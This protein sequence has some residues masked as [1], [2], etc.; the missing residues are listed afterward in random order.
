MLYYTVL[1]LISSKHQQV[2]A[3][4]AAGI[5]KVDQNCEIP[6]ITENL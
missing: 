1:E 5:N 6:Q 3:G 2:L 4:D